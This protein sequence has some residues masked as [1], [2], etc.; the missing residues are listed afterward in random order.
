MRRR[1]RSSRRGGPR[2]KLEWQFGYGTTAG[3]V[4]L[5][6][7]T[8]VCHWVVWPV[9]TLDQSRQTYDAD[10]VVN[11]TDLTLVRSLNYGYY[12]IQD[13]VSTS[14][15]NTDAV[16]TLTFGLIKFS[17]ADP[18][19]VD[20][21]VLDAGESVPGPATDP[22]A[23]WIWRNQAAAA[24]FGSVSQQMGVADIT[25]AQSRAQRKLSAG[26]G[27]MQVLEFNIWGANFGDARN[28]H[29]YFESRCL[30]KEA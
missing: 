5:L 23:D 8:L 22:T 16:V 2:R 4:E 18:S 20:S 3:S 25:T 17:Y 21:I 11:P 26:E 6:H 27:I 12:W 29:Y 13:P 15:S 14:E 19:L 7:N 24:S 30:L 10:V 28:V 9:A 1:F